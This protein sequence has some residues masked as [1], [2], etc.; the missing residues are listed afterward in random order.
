M[1]FFTVMFYATLEHSKEV[2]QLSISELV[3]KIKT[4]ISGPHM[5]RISP[6]SWG[7]VIGISTVQPDYTPKVLFSIKKNNLQQST[8]MTD[9]GILCTI[10]YSKAMFSVTRKQYIYGYTKYG[11]T[12]C[13]HQVFSS[14]N[15]GATLKSIH[16]CLC[17][18][19]KAEVELD[20]FQVPR[21]LFINITS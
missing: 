3:E 15:Y 9:V 12:C 20:L 13:P 11:D 17:P 4:S 7:L 2:S 19:L 6:L 21:H 10:S 14:I 16:S 1:K 5:I 18:L 8:L